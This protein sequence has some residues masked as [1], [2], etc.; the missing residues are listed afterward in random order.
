MERAYLLDFFDQVLF[1]S[2]WLR[3]VSLLGQGLGM[4]GDFHERQRGFA[5]VRGYTFVNG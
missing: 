2:V 3:G 1:F 4:G 5:G